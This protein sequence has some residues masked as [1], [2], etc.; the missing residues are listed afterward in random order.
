MT[1]EGGAFAEF[2]S[3]QGGREA[4]IGVDGSVCGREGRDGE[5]GGCLIAGLTIRQ[6]DATAKVSLKRIETG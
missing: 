1:N 5:G 6:W 3:A 4:G 2:E